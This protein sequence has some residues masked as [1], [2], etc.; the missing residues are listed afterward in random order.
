MAGIFNKALLLFIAFNDR[1]S[2]PHGKIDTR[3]DRD[4]PENHHE[5]DDD[6]FIA[7]VSCD[8]L[9]DIDSDGHVSDIRIVIIMHLD[10]NV[11]IVLIFLPKKTRHRRLNNRS[12]LSNVNV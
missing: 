8:E 4:N 1:L 3:S 11:V 7:L 12:T 9:L 10:G 5:R 6:T 2:C